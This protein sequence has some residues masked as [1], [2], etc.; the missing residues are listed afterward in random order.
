MVKVAKVNKQHL[1][2]L[3]T[4][5]AIGLAMPPVMAAR[6]IRAR[7]GASRQLTAGATSLDGVTM[8]LS[9]APRILLKTSGAP[10]FSSYSPQPDVYVIDLPGAAR[11]ESLSLPTTYPSFISSVT[12]ENA[13][14]LGT[15]LTRVTIRFAQ[16]VPAHTSAVDGGLAVTFDADSVPSVSEKAT[17]VVPPAVE[18]NHPVVSVEAAKVPDVAPVVSTESRSAAEAL[19]PPQPEQAATTSFQRATQLRNVTTE[20]SGPGLQVVLAT[21]GTAEYT[22]FRLTNPLRLVVDLKGVNNKSQ[23]GA[24]NLGDP[25]VKRVRVAQFKGNPEPVTRVVLDLDEAVDYHVTK[26]A[27]AVRISFGSELVQAP[28]VSTDSVAQVTPAAEK[29]AQVAKVA[30]PAPAV[31]KAVPAPPKES[32]FAD[33]PAVVAVAEAPRATRSIGRGR[34]SETLVVRSSADQATP[35][36]RRSTR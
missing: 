14:E 34:K 18:V 4:L 20:G 15:S 25:L 21:N 32:V 9:P 23:P 1:L 16:S 33:V 17:S 5:V 11:A 22:V 19:V 6:S 30:A 27:S 10:S 8:E 31:V 26:T 2:V 35:T 24:L 13:T 12:A 28:S 29:P 7:Q 3:G 36:P